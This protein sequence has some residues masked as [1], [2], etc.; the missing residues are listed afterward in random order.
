MFFAVLN[1]GS[2]HE[3]SG[4]IVERAEAALQ[5]LPAQLAHNPDTIALPPYFPDT[6]S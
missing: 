4:N 1:L 5:R 2:T 6:P 3:G